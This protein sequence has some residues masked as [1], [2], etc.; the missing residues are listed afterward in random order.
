MMTWKTAYA[1]SLDLLD[2]SAVLLTK[3]AFWITLLLIAILL[4]V[5]RF[6]R[7]RPQAEKETTEIITTT[8]YTPVYMVQESAKKIAE[9]LEVLKKHPLRAYRLAI[10]GHLLG[11]MGKK[12]STSS[13]E[14]SQQLGINIKEYINYTS[15]VLDDA[16]THLRGG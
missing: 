6:W 13:S 3:K 10:E 7:S 12:M 15:D 4:L 1:K 2:R 5:R 8:K 9:S 14:L 11:V 16:E